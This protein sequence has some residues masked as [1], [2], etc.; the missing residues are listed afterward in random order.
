MTAVECHG[1]FKHLLPCFGTLVS[2]VCNP[3]IRL[4]QHR[5]TKIFLRVPPVRRTRCRAAGAENALVKS[6]KF[7][8]IFFALSKLSSLQKSAYEIVQAYITYIWCFG[9]SLE[10]WLD[11]FVLLVEKS[12]V[13]YEI[14]D[15]ICMWQWVNSCFMCR[16][17][18]DST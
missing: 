7:L 2:R 4:H 10:E 13:G 15:N 6:I 16:L 8:S 3:P 17:G 5:G 18:R 1:I 9:V 14:L 11:G 12:Q